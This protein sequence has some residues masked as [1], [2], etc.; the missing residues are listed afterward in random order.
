MNAYTYSFNKYLL[1]TYYVLNTILG[2]ENKV[3]GRTSPP[4]SWSLKSSER[5]RYQSRKLVNKSH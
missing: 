5:K 4:P 3:I 2:T 1:N